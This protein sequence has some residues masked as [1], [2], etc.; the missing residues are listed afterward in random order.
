MVYENCACQFYIPNA[1]TPNG[2]GH[3][4][5]FLPK[6]Q[7]LFINY[8]LKIYN[9]YGQLIFVSRN[10]GNGWDGLFGGQQQPTGTYVW[11][12]NYKD[13]LTGKEVRKNGTVVLIR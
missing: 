6:Y 5:V 7:C 13:N 1:F 10:A 3:N 8:E 4:D 12:L 9:R 2:D 11:M